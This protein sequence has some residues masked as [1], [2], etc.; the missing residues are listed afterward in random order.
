[1]LVDHLRRVVS[2]ISK[3][4]Q[5]VNEEEA[6]SLRKVRRDP[7]SLLGRILI[8]GILSYT[9]I[10]NLQNV[11]SQ[12]EYTKANG[13]PFAEQLV[14]FGSGILGVGSLGVILCRMPIL[15]AG[16]IGSFLLDVTP[17]MHDF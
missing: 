10:E 6:R 13:V 16:A 3:V 5:S 14:P 8:G 15:A 1:M 9:A 7:P 2:M 12:I 11:E 4:D 17:T